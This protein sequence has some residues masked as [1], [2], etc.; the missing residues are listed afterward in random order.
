MLFATV[1]LTL[2]IVFSI[3]SCRGEPILIP[4]GDARVIGQLENG[5]YE[6]TSA[7]ILEYYKIKKELEELKKDR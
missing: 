5:N 6:V 7:F 3:N 4:L 1:I 2:L